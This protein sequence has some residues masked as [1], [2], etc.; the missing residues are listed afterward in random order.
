MQKRKKY[1]NFF[2]KVKEAREL[3][4]QL[5]DYVID[6]YNEQKTKYLSEI[7]SID[8]KGNRSYMSLPNIKYEKD[9]DKLIWEKKKEKLNDGVEKI[10]DGANKIKGA[11]ENGIRNINE[12]FAIE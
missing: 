4:V 10:K 5:P 7:Y 2:K 11:I 12:G 6:E 9:I 1:T 8:K 3:G